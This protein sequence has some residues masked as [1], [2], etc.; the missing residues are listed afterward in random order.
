M[1]Q[2][3]GSIDRVPVR[4]AVTFALTICFLAVGTY[5]RSESLFELSPDSF[6]KP[7]MIVGGTTE[8]VQGAGRYG[9]PALQIAPMNG[10]SRVSCQ[11]FSKPQLIPVFDRFRV[12][13]WVKAP[14]A[15]GE[16]ELEFC[17][18]RTTIGTPFA[19]PFALTRDWRYLAYDIGWPS[20]FRAEAFNVRVTTRGSG[21]IL[22]SDF[23]FVQADTLLRL[24]DLLEPVET[25]AQLLITRDGVEI[26][27]I[28]RALLRKFS[29]EP[30]SPEAEGFFGI[31]KREN[32]RI[33]VV[34]KSEG[35]F[36]LTA[37][38]MRIP[39]GLESFF[40]TARFSGPLDS[41]PTLVFRQYGGKGPINET[42]SPPLPTPQPKSAY[43]ESHEPHE[44][45]QRGQGRDRN[46]GNPDTNKEE[47]GS[48]AQHFVAMGGDGR[49]SSADRLVLMFSFPSAAGTYRMESLSVTPSFATTA[50]PS[51]TFFVDQVGYEAGE[52]LRFIVA[53]KEFPDGA[54]A[55][56]R[57]VDARGNARGGRLTSLGRAIGQRESDWGSYY[58]EGVVPAPAPGTYTLDVTTKGQTASVDPIRVA[59]QLRLKET[60]ELAYRFYYYQRCGCEI[61]GWHGPCH[62][63]D[64]R[65]PDGGHADVTGGYHN[66]GDFHKHLGDNTPVSV[67]AMVRAYRDQ[68]KF[69]DQRDTDGNGRADLLDEAVWGADWLKKMVNPKTG[70]LWTNV[71]NDIDYH[72][73]PERDT[74][75]KPGTNDDRVINTD[76]PGDLGALVIAAWAALAQFVPEKG[77]LE[78]AHQAWDAYEERMLEGYEPRQIVAALELY[79]ATQDEKYLRAAEKVVANAL[80]L[81][82]A[83]GWFAAQ[84]DGPPVF[85]IVDEGTIPAA[86]A[87]YALEQRKG[88]V[89]PSTAGARPAQRPGARP[90]QRPDATDAEAGRD[91]EVKES[92]R[93]YF[94]WSFRMADNPFGL[95]RGYTGGEPFYFKSREDW[96]GGSNSQ[97]CSVAW[98]A[99]LAAR[100]FKDDAE[101]S[102]QLRAHAANQ[103]HWILG[104]NPLRLCMFEGKGNLERIYFHHL[105]AEIPG[106]PRGA[107]PG[108]IPN[109][110]IREPGN[111]DRPWFDLREKPGSPP[112][113][114]SAEP[115]LPHNAYYL[116]ALAAQD[117][118]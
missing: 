36:V 62:M 107:V 86:L 65:L 118:D 46:R 80:R 71:T 106:H 16:I 52:P 45:T 25:L 67:Y 30:S 5:A 22:I 114:E 113:A 84:P 72:G 42:Q 58:F 96:F 77:Y 4:G 39:V 83:Q 19:S 2:T 74:D 56:Y 7:H 6:E 18:A 111:A 102:A 61:P 24:A 41:A 49:E 117:T 38:P 57:L 48:A 85:R 108:A 34:D 87:L 93:R 100:V 90:A 15:G 44:R 89:P 26:T 91:T 43:H 33:L 51:V 3:S 82:D 64:G 76:D 63:D 23:R 78:A 14:N 1:N 20:E 88:S 10:E 95:V 50:M 35:R 92:L 8:W 103:I 28:P 17:D 94:A 60:G 27:Q 109:G 69:F 54:D 79:K 70:G 11:F 21:E 37:E 99:Y 32:R 66:A 115:W 73:I 13:A 98:A 40:G 29:D 104:M 116:L 105:Y 101:F 97:Y 9:G 31:E 53:T 68:Q 59:P 112:G 47:S 110:I 75:G 12:E 55:A 81:Q